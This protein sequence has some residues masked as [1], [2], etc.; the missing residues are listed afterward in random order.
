MFFNFILDINSRG[1]GNKVEKVWCG[2]IWKNYFKYFKLE[3][4]ELYIFGGV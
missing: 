4:F 3:F 2:D 1:I